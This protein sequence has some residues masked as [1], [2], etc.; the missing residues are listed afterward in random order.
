MI[1]RVEKEDS[2]GHKRSETTKAVAEGFLCSCVCITSS[3]SQDF[4][5]ASVDICTIQGLTLVETLHRLYLTVTLIHT[6]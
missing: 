4:P 2:A 5:P 1:S 6:C 3:E